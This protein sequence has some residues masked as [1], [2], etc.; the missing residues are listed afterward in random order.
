[1]QKQKVIIWDQKCYFGVFWAAFLKIYYYILDQ[2]TR[3]SLTAKFGSKIENLRFG[4]KKYLILDIF[5][6]KFWTAFL[7]IYCHI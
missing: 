7:K 4:V 2:R 1:M 6:L 3:K 5:G